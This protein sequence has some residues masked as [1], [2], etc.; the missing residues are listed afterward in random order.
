[1]ESYKKKGVIIKETTWFQEKNK[2]TLIQ[3]I[4]IH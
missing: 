3:I 2:M 4:F 1:M